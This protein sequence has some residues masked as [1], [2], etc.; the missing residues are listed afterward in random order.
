MIQ[1]RKITEPTNEPTKKG[2]HYVLFLIESNKF[3][4]LMEVSMK[5]AAFWDIA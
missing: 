5:M 4:V 1:H 3:H 2:S